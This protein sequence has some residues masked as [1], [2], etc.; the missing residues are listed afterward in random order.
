METAANNQDQLYEWAT[1]VGLLCFSTLPSSESFAD[2][3]KSGLF[4]ANEGQTHWWLA[5][6]GHFPFRHCEKTTWAPCWLVK[7][8]QSSYKLPVFA[9]PGLVL[10]EVGKLSFHAWR[11]EEWTSSQRLSFLVYS[12]LYQPSWFCAHRLFF[13]TLFTNSSKSFLVRNIFLKLFPDAAF[14][15]PLLIIIS[16]LD[17]LFISTKSLTCC[18][19]L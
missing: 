15:L 3:L 4:I 12:P 13:K 2:C 14:V 17:A 6:K 18:Q 16:F 8:R 19:L 7:K 9:T 10:L 5:S 1:V 11:K